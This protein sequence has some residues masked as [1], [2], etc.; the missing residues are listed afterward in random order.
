MLYYVCNVMSINVK[1]KCYVSTD[2]YFRY[3]CSPWYHV[4]LSFVVASDDNVWRF[5][6]DH[7]RPRGTYTNS[8]GGFM[9]GH[10]GCVGKSDHVRTL[11]VDLEVDYSVSLCVGLSWVRWSWSRIGHERV[12]HFDIKILNFDFACYSYMF[13][14]IFAPNKRLHEWVFLVL[15]FSKVI[16]RWKKSRDMGVT[17]K[18]VRAVRRM[19]PEFYVLCFFSMLRLKLSHVRKLL[20]YGDKKTWTYGILLRACFSYWDLC[21]KFS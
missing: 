1:T 19:T 14:C 6:S 12:T 7:V 3:S 18:V 11:F 9:C 13:L 2:V 5:K 16:F 15:T 4:G 10:V 21:M 17:S 8:F 20:V